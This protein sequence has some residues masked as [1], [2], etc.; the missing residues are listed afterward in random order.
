MISLHLS[1]ITPHVLTVCA[2]PRIIIAT[3]RNSSFEGLRYA[4]FIENILKEKPLFRKIRFAPLLGIY[5]SLLFMDPS[6]YGGVPSPEE[7]S[8][9]EGR[10]QVSTNNSRVYGIVDVP[11][12]RMNWDIA[13][14]LPPP[15]DLVWT[16]IVE[17]F[18]RRPLLDYRK[19]MASTEESSVT[20]AA[21]DNLNPEVRKRR[22]MIHSRWVL[23]PHHFL[24]SLCALST[25]RCAGASFFE[26]CFSGAVRNC[27][28]YSDES[29]DAKDARG[30]WTA[31][32][33]AF[34]SSRVCKCIDGRVRF[35]RKRPAGSVFTTKRIIAA[36]ERTRVQQICTVFQ[37]S[38]T[39]SAARHDLQLLQNCCGSGR[40][41]CQGTFFS[42]ERTCP[43]CSVSR[44][45]LDLPQRPRTQCSA[46]F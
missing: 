29:S 17:T 39:V 14:Y 31:E 43:L 40:N 7:E 15:I 22:S 8:V 1:A 28:R 45:G 4:A 44:S 41:S 38:G 46:R 19:Q 36:F 16:Q 13:R 26:A 37:S 34:A 12:T 42:G 18:V 11:E 27:S 9:L 24:S 30:C 21:G 23:T 35:G 25:H 6:N 3:P 20:K 5:D 2:V 33:S 32:T 10:V